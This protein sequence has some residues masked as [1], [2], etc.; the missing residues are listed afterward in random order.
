MSL[1]ALK[2]VNVLFRTS[3][4]WNVCLSRKSFIRSSPA[5]T[6][7]RSWSWAKK[8]VHA[9]ASRRPACLRTRSSSLGRRKRLPW[10]SHASV[11]SMRRRWG[12]FL[13][14]LLCL[15]VTCGLWSDISLWSRSEKRQPSRWKWKS[16]SIN[17]SSDRKATVCRR[18]WRAP[19]CRWRCPR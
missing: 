17:T 9:S 19:E 15:K 2:Y 10:Q 6:T 3:A 1:L 16:L 7:D 5:H 13:L 12:V 14:L 18:S 8:Q 11:L 4:Q